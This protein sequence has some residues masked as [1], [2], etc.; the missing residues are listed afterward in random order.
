MAPLL[1][2]ARYH[3]IATVVLEAIRAAFRMMISQDLTVLEQ[4]VV[5]PLGHLGPVISVIGIYFITMKT[6]LSITLVR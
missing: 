3:F 4:G 2:R 5:Q 6:P 1:K